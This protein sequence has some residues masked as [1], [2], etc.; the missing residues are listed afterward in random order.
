MTVQNSQTPNSKEI[1]TEFF[2]YD[3]DVSDILSL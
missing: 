2:N 1:S 3:Q